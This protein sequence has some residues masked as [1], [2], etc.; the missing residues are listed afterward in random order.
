MSGARHNYQCVHCG[1]IQ[2]IQEDVG[3]I[4][5]FIYYEV[6]CPHCKTATSHLDIG[7]DT[8]DKYELY[9]YTLDERYFK[10]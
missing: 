10:Y 4:K 8:L 1:K 6:Y 5:D 7:N 2:Y 3:S 9:D